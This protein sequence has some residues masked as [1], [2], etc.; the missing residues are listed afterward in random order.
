MA[1]GSVAA[2]AVPKSLLCIDTETTGVSTRTD[3]VVSLAML[4]LNDDLTVRRG[5]HQMFNPGIPIPAAATA[6]H[7]IRDV[8]VAG[9]PGFGTV[10]GRV[11]AALGTNIVIGY[12]VRFDLAVLNQEFRRAG[13]PR[14]R[15]VLVIDPYVVFCKNHPRNL[16]AAVKTYLGEEHCGAHDARADAQATVRVLRAQVGSAWQ[17]CVEAR[18]LGGWP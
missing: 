4:W 12:N 17:S 5:L 9:M 11:R 16:S 14:L 7:G 10:A 18:T 1:E 15:N 3:R 13:L 2:L 6:V 8:D